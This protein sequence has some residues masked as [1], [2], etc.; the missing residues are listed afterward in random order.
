MCIAEDEINNIK[1]KYVYDTLELLENAVD[2]D[3]TMCPIYTYYVECKNLLGN[4]TVADKGDFIREYSFNGEKIK[5][6]M[7]SPLRQ[8]EAQREVMRKIWESNTSKIKKILQANNFDFYRRVLVVAANKETILNTSKAPKDVKNKVIRLDTLVKKLEYDFYNRKSNEVLS[9]KKEMENIAQSYVELSCEENID[10]Y[11]YYKSKFTGEKV[12]NTNLKD[13]LILFRKRRS[14]E[15]KLPAY[16]IFTN[17]ELD[18]IVELK[19]KTIDELKSADI[20][21]SIKIK[22]HGEAIINEINK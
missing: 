11:E 15:M 14:I 8:V 9:N 7:C 2:D 21:S 6:G 20:L 16:Y 10:Y 18:K 17:D 12:S 5:K 19:P 13:R 22:T 3:D 1:N 4:I